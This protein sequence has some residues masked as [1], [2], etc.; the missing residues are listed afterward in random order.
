[1]GYFPNGTEGQIYEAIYCAKC[2]H[3]NGYDGNGACAVMVAHLLHNYKECDKPDSI[4]HELIPLDGIEN[5][6]CKM[7]VES[8]RVY[9]GT[10]PEHLRQWADK[11][12]VLDVKPSAGVATTTP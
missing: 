9:V 1:M 6:Q 7:F 12:R 5:G 2:I 4:L 11:N 10:F 3:R 8:A